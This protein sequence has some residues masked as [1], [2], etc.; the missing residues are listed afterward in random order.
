VEKIAN[1]YKGGIYLRIIIKYILKNIK[2]KKFRTFILLLS[3]AMSTALF[4]ASNGISSTME[5]IGI[6]RLQQYTGNS[7]IVIRTI[8]TS[9]DAFFSPTAAKEWEQDMDYIY[10]AI[11]ITVPYTD[12]NKDETIHLDI[13]GIDLAQ[14]QKMNTVIFDQENDVLPFDGNKIIISS[15]TAQEYKLELDDTMAVYINGEKQTFRICGIAQQTGFFQ[16][17]GDATMGVVPKETLTAIYEVTGKA[18]MAFIKVKANENK[19]NLL[20][21]LA[22]EYPGYLVREAVTEEE[23]EE[24]VGAI[25]TTFLLV[26]VVV[27]IM[28]IFIIY[29]AFKVITTERI[30]VIGTLRSVGATK[31]TTNFL[32]ILESVVYGILGG[33]IGC[34]LG[35]GLLYLMSMILNPNW[36]VEGGLMVTFSAIHLVLAFV[37]AIVLSFISAIV[38]ILKVTRV[39]LK[40]IIL[41]KTEVDPIKSK[42]S[43]VKGVIG[44]LFVAVSIFLPPYAQRELAIPLGLTCILLLMSGIILIVPYAANLFSTVMR[45]FFQMIFGNVG[46]LA[47]KNLRDEKNI[48]TNISLLGIAI[49]SLLMI[50]T[51]TDGALTEMNQYYTKTPLYKLHVWTWDGVMDLNFEKGVRDLPNVDDARGFYVDE[52]VEIQGEN[53]AVQLLEGIDTK[54]FLN[55]WNIDIEGDRQALVDRL[56][57]GRNIIIGNMLRNQLNAKSGDSITLQMTNGEKEYKIIGFMDTAHENGSYAIISDDNFKQDMNVDVFTGVRIKTNSNSADIIKNFRDKY[58]ADRPGAETVAEIAKED[59]ENNQQQFDIVRGFIFIA[60][61]IGILSVANNLLI[62]FMQRK[63]DIAMLRSVG[64]SQVQIRKMIF[65]EALSAG[66]L[67]GMI[68]VIGGTIMIAVVPYILAALEQ[69]FV[70]RYSAIATVVFL[71]AGMVITIFASISPALKSS[72]LNIIETIKME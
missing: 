2:E 24:Q 19:E 31:K 14:L 54:Q 3:V 35:V 18:N 22:A 8:D 64:M 6:K 17:F 49:A 4:F 20:E 36:K 9:P 59:I 43:T 48:V 45:A 60:L 65:I 62:S 30:I 66:F 44:V 28:S 11:E 39:S 23:I 63:H 50:I 67:G 57:E 58:V 10:E 41:G 13:L 38:P 15:K 5:D 47:V 52:E 26:T 27:A 25:T 40:D 42:R 7:D 71:L 56:D 1:K 72:K 32:L 53:S 68:G 46:S 51:V 12:V 61:F 37:L 70:V 21:K 33:V 34:I 16:E 29:S 69:R 55:Y